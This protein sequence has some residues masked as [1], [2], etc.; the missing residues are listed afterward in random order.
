M[1]F[2]SKFKIPTLLGLTV[3]LLG[4]AIGLYL[5]LK[6]DI[7]SSST[8]DLVP[9]NIVVTNIT[10]D[11]A[12]ISWQTS[13][14]NVSF[15]TFGQKNPEE[16]TALDD[17]NSGAENSAGP[18]PYLNHYVTLKNLLPKTT[19]Q[20]KITSGRVV[21]PVEEFQTGAPSS[22]QTDFSGVVGSVLDGD[23]PLEDG[24][25]YLSIPDS[26]D[27]SFLI[28]SGS[29]LIPLSQIR[30]KD[31]SGIFLPTEGEIAKLTIRTGKGDTKVLF[32]LKANA[33]PLPPIKIGE[34]LD[35]TTSETPSPSPQKTDLYDLNSD[36]KLNAADYAIVLLN[37]GKKPKKDGED[38]FKKS[39]LNKDG[40]VDKKDLDL[41][42]QKLKD[43]SN[44]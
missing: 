12:V 36:G 23:L 6:E 38:A 22:E 40:V 43:L 18:K 5:I 1:K 14:P 34:D 21:S 42:N 31:L 4:L 26:I 13:L 20:Y 3:I 9:Q 25:V 32:K 33:L 28:K 11:S 10:E 16:L 19:Y 41:L 39:D 8:P 24:I 7:L 44:P 27:Q 35:L 37:L 15:I 29:F 2:F 30:K 17:R